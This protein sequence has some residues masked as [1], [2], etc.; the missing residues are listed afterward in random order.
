[1]G[2]MYSIGV[3]GASHSAPQDV[4]DIFA[5]NIALRIRQF[6]VISY[7]ASGPTNIDLG[8]TRFSGTITPGSGGV[9]RT[10]T[11]LVSTDPSASF[12]ARSNDTTLM[13]GTTRADLISYGANVDQGWIYTP[14]VD[15]CPIIQPGEAFSISGGLGTGPVDIS[16]FAIVEEMS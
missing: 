16:F 12:T 4:L 6:G 10:P 7:N 8:F 11:S 14:P 15:L 1:M 9:A 5:G 3:G 13:T 2:K